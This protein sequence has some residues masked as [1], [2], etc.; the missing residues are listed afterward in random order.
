MPDRLYW[1][2]V[3]PLL[4]DA[5]TAL[6]QS[7]I[8]QPF[9]L[10]GGT[11]LSLRLGHRMSDDID[12]FTDEPYDSIDFS[13]IDKFLIKTFPYVSDLAQGPVGMGVSYLVGNSEDDTVK[14][15]LFYTDH[16]IQ[17][18]LQI[19]SYRLATVEEII[20]MKIDIVQRKARKKDFWDI[21]ELL[22]THTPA[23]MISLHA[24]RYPYGH[25]ENLIRTNF[26][27]FSR[28]DEDFD[29]ICL[30]GKYWELIKL[31]IVRALKV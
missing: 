31:D 11:S 16:F 9:R 26:T 19:G 7:D 6:V 4:K 10:V 18:A 17:P 1:N 25:D 5:L 27:D 24:Q 3:R 30:R 13:A 15:D 12:L 28:A 22:G 23:Q 21:H 14:L 2:T 20:A 8:F 29:P